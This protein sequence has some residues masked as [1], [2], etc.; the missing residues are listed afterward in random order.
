M[1]EI[2]YQKKKD[3]LDLAKRASLMAYA[4]YSNFPVGAALISKTGK[5]FTGCNVENAS[6]GLS[7]CA[8]R[9]ALASM[10][11]SG[12]KT[13]YAIAIFAQKSS[14]C[15]PCGA[16]RQWLYEFAPDAM[17]ITEDLNGEIVTSSV[18]SLIPFAFG[19]EN[20]D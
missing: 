12:E 5:F 4:P 6:Y 11:N 15:Y 7:L 19:P 1:I 14:N 18:K 17:V 9:N 16:C 2:N 13:F 3:L 20:L 8:E 10:I